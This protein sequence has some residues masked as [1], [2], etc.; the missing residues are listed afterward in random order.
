[1]SNTE[2]NKKDR[3]FYKQ[4]PYLYVALAILGMYFSNRSKIAMISAIVLLVCGVVIFTMRN[5]YRERQVYLKQKAR[6]KDEKDFAIR[7][8]TKNDKA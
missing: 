8:V 7:I 4:R 3:M 1:M 6:A 5:A 2:V